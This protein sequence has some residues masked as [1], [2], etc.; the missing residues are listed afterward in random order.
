MQVKRGRSPKRIS[1]KKKN[2][3]KLY[4]KKRIKSE[5]GGNTE[6]S[7]KYILVTIIRP[8]F[9]ISCKLLP[10]NILFSFCRASFLLNSLSSN[11]NILKVANISDI[12]YSF[13]HLI[14]NP[15]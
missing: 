4:K 6:F 3:F 13:G 10:L 14:F 8:S 9:F 5:G 1:N 15:P 12:Q 7:P 2:L 11:F